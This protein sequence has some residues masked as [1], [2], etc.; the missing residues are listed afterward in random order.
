M[1]DEKEVKEVKVSAQHKSGRDGGQ[2]ISSPRA[3]CQ[4]SAA[5][6]ACQAS[7]A[8]AAC[9]ASAASDVL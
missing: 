4:A 9:Q 2:L 1:E 8:R 5:R 3:A 6:A 7:A